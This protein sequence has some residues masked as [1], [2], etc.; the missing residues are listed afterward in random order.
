MQPFNFIF[1]TFFLLGNLLFCE[2]IVMYTT[3]EIYETNAILKKQ[4]W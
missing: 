2:T 4:C 3:K 1:V